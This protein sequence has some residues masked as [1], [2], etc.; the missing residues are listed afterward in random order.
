MTS[1]PPIFVSISDA[2]LGADGISS[3]SSSGALIRP[4]EGSPCRS[5]PRADCMSS[6]LATI[7]LYGSAGVVSSTSGVPSVWQNRIL[8]SKVFWQVGHRFISFVEAA[9]SEARA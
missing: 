9:G 4:G 6:L 7:V 3:G 5:A 8:S 1:L 2:D